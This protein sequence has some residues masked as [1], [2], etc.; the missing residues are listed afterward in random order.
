[1]EDQLKI[2]KI[3][4]RSVL[5]PMKA[6]ATFKQIHNEYKERM[7][8]EIPMQKLGCRNMKQLID[9]LPDV[10]YLDYDNKGELRVYA[11]P[12]KST[13]HIHR[14]VSK[15]KVGNMKGDGYLLVLGGLLRL[16]NRAAVTSPTFMRQNL[17]V[18]LLT[19]TV[20]GTPLSSAMDKINS[21]GTED[22][23]RLIIE[24]MITSHSHKFAQI[25]QIKS[26][27]E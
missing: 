14:M 8:K 9:Q 15:Q 7:G 23:E 13:A 4:L 20:T 5:L 26:Y 10:A 19:L 6:G 25:M 3:E 18:R 22:V 16:C 24:L 1:M 2:F 11:V 17:S 12:D 21:S 27:H